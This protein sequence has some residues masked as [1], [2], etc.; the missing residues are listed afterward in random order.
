MRSSL[1]HAARHLLPSLLL[2]LAACDRE[3]PAA[4]AP[5]PPPSQNLAM[6]TGEAR[7][8]QPFTIEQRLLDAVRRGDRETLERALER[9]A[10][11]HAKDDLQRSTIL[12]AT[13]D[14]GDV[15]LVRWLHGKGAA[16]DDA[17]LG[18]RTAASFAA[19]DGRLDILRY[20]IENGAVADRPD[21]QKRTPL[22]HAALGDHADAV[23]FLLDR[24]ADVNVRD[25]FGDTP[26]IVACGKGNAAT[27][28][29]LLARGA[30]A[31]LK[32]QEGRTARER[33]APETAPCLNLGPP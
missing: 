25:Q 3:P 4:P 15:A 6:G 33:S 7:N 31:S 29:L 22:F 16:L 10:T 13:K 30:D 24:G 9:G 19:A 32:D 12:L 11:V 21:G 23:A 28:A 27:A 2:V 1:T 5:H 8:P 17:D 20:L 14:A 18:G 26:L